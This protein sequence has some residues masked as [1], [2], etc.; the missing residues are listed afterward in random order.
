[1]RSTKL[2]YIFFFDIDGTIIGDISAQVCEWTLLTTYEKSKI[3]QFKKNLI[4]QLENGLLR[5]HIMNYIELIRSKHEHVELFIY[6]ASDAKW[7]AFLVPCIE[8]VIGIKF[9]RP[10]FT[11][12]Q[13]TL[14]NHEYRKSLSKVMPTAFSKIKRG[15]SLQDISHSDLKH[16]STLI[17]NNH[18]L[19]KNEECRG[20]LCPTYNF[21]D[22]YD[23]LRLLSEHAIQQSY[24]EISI[25]MSTY[26]LFPNISD[27]KKFSYQVFKALYFN[28]LGA[29]I[30][31][32]VNAKQGNKRT[33][34]F[35]NLLGSVMHKMDYSNLKD[36]VIKTINHGVSTKL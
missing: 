12:N 18:V 16:H 36:S 30:T 22:I 5:P 7:A 4:T 32:T 28:H 11:R 19:M 1:M 15:L 23:V 25:Q 3:P 10:L 35:W 26:G 9:N 31:E 34:Q 6:T 24:V 2:P 21:I 29:K 33:D 20:I 13:C 14:V 17:D 8:N 27:S